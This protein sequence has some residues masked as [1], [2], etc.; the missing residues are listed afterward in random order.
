M[1]NPQ[2]IEEHPINV[3]MV[4]DALKR[5]KK[6][7]GELNFRSAKTEEYLDQFP[8][9][10]TKDAEAAIEA[11][12]K[13]KITRLREVQLHKLIDICP[14]TVEAVRTILSGYNISLSADDQKKI[15]SIIEQYA[16]KKQQKVEAET[17]AVSSPVVEEKKIEKEKKEEK[18]K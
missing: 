14:R 6:R 2:I 18:K 10:K 13:L 7:D 5:I 15:V 12:E 16:P 11:L 3:V 4:H 9:M 17:S 8:L 1:S